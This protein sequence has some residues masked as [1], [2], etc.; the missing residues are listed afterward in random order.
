MSTND[1]T[2]DE[3]PPAKRQKLDDANVKSQA[4]PEYNFT[5]QLRP[6]LKVK[7]L[8]KT[9]AVESKLKMEC[10]RDMFKCMRSNCD[11]HTNNKRTFYNHLRDH[12]RNDPHYRGN[13]SRCSYCAYSND[14]IDDLMRHIIN[15][16]AY[17]NYGCSY[18]FYRSVSK[19]S[20]EFHILCYHKDKPQEIL[21]HDIP[22]N[23]LKFNSEYALKRARISK[24]KS[25]SS[26]GCQGNSFI[27]NEK[28]NKFYFKNS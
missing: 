4:A 22:Y 2:C 6:W 12:E 24:I 15:T 25:V 21:S 3:E 14:K 20:V 11:F 18:C 28:E 27:F 1:Q 19:I 17:D 8:N 5:D 7:E 26:L 16:H 13:F 23:Q 9:S 10:L